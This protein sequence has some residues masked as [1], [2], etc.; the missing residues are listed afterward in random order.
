[1]MPFVFGLFLI[2]VI[3]GALRCQLA[4]DERP[5]ARPAPYALLMTAG[6]LAGSVACGLLGGLAGAAF[7]SEQAIDVGVYAGVLFGGLAGMELGFTSAARK[8]SRPR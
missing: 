7:W 6:G 4:L 8:G 5:G 3:L 2:M 1:M